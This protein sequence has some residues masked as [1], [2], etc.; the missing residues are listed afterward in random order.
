MNRQEQSAGYHGMAS[1]HQ[2]GRG[3][4]LPGF[5]QLLPKI[6]PRLLKAGESLDWSIDERPALGLNG[7]VQIGICQAK[8]GGLLGVGLADSKL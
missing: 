4:V 3:Q 8:G 7:A 1:P 6:Y 2:S 5:N